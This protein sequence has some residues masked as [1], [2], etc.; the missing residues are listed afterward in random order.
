[1]VVGF[2]RDEVQ[3]SIG[4]RARYAVQ[5]QQLGTGHAVLQAA[6]ILEA[7]GVANKRVLIAL[8]ERLRAKDIES[9]APNLEDAPADDIRAAARAELIEDS[10]RL[11][12]AKKR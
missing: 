7:G 10:R 9:S 5:E 6:S 2:Q 8:R 12:A 1:M 3:K 11:A 4:E